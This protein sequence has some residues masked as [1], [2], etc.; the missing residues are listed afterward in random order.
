MVEV[1]KGICAHLF[2]A[3]IQTCKV[4]WYL[5][6]FVNW[7]RYWTHRYQ[8]QILYWSKHK[9][10][11]ILFSAFF[12]TSNRLSRERCARVYAVH[13]QTWLAGLWSPGNSS[14]LL[15]LGLGKY[16]SR[17][18]FLC[19]LHVFICLNK[20]SWSLKSWLML[21]YGFSPKPAVFQHWSFE[22]Q[23]EYPLQTFNMTYICNHKHL[24]QQQNHQWPWD[25][26]WTIIVRLFRVSI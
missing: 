21:Y 6:G 26:K 22:K 8:T 16:V 18:L 19:W 5:A 15:Q 24:Q 10:T 25:H 17:R 7:H 20:H 13:F 14:T 2:L 23:N 12:D 4:D 9:N 1:F 3:V 11:S